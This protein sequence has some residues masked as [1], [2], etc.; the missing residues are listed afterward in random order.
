MNIEAVIGANYGDEGK[1]LF[2]SYLCKNR[3]KPI[4]VLSNGGC[5]R[6]H[7]V[8][9][10]TRNRH[11]FHHF[12]SGTLEGAPSIF[13]HDYLL[14]P[15]LYVQEFHELLD[16]GMMIPRSFRAPS[17]IIQLPGDFL[18]N[19]SLEKHRQKTNSQHG[20]CG[21]GI[22]E[23]IYRNCCHRP[24]KF[25]AFASMTYDDR[26]KYM[27]DEIEW[28][29]EN[30]LK[31]ENVKIDKE[32]LKIVNSKGFID[33]FMKDTDFMAQHSFELPT[34]HLLEI[35]Y[36]PIL[37]WRPLNAIIENAQGLLLDKAYA[38]KDENG[39][40]DVHSTPSMTGLEGAI[41]ALSLNSIKPASVT[42]N[43]VTRTYFT[44]HG[45]GPF[46]EFT[47]GLAYRDLTNVQNDYQGAMRFGEMT[48][49]HAQKLIDRVNA[50]SNY[51]NRNIVLTHLN[52]AKAPSV[53]SE[54]ASYFSNAPN[55]V[56]HIG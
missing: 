30:R 37:K 14:N 20:S 16:Y 40:V 48:E 23:T 6:G 15:I 42:A 9:S 34:D 49:E 32:L 54:A 17:C 55:A 7:T 43:Y 56:K 47:E 4:V 36:E 18:I 52:E 50:D 2:T 5:Q 25:S 26:K 10:L 3:E 29:I 28:Q 39:H 33:H 46:P 12:G 19:Q 11:V 35:D 45:A 38:P 8:D 22:W 44:R 21:M 51:N 1:G 13:S 24:L 41:S 53:L 31:P 27:A